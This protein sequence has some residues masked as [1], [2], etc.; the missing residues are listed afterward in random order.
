[1][2]PSLSLIPAA[3][4][5]RLQNGYYRKY[6]LL[7]LF[8]WISSAAPIMAE[9]LVKSNFESSVT[10]YNPWAGVTDTGLLKV[11]HGKQPAVDNEGHTVNPEFPPSVAVG[12][13]NGDGLQDLVIADSLGFFWYYPNSGTPTQAKFT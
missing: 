7:L 1:M 8:A 11:L 6:F 12:D 10:T 5:H 3:S 9:D 4:L 13:L 2:N